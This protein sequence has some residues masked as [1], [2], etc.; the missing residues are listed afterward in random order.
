MSLASNSLAI[1]FLSDH[2]LFVNDVA[3]NP[4]SGYSWK[5]NIASCLSDSKSGLAG[6]G[7]VLHDQNGIFKACGAAALTCNQSVIAELSALILGLEISINRGVEVQELVEQCNHF[8]ETFRNVK[9]RQVK[10]L[11]NKAANQ[12]ALMGIYGDEPGFWQDEPAL[13]IV[14]ILIHDVI[15]RWVLHEETTSGPS[16]ELIYC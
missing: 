14:D 16:F 4:P 11:S 2:G 12:K 7:C 8:L 1:F 15:G 13:V 10:L 3:W 5:L 9:I 6:A